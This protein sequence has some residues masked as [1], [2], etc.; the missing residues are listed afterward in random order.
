MPTPTGLAGTSSQEQVSLVWSGAAGAAGYIVWRSLDGSSYTALGGLPTTSATSYAD[1]AVSSGT[2][3]SY[4]VQSY[5]AGSSNNRSATT[6]AAQVL[7]PPAPPAVLLEAAAAAQVSLSWNSSTGAKSYDLLRGTTQ[8]GPYAPVASVTDLAFTDQSVS[9]S[10]TCFYVVRA[11]GFNGGSSPDSPEA[12]ANTAL[13]S[14]TGTRLATFGLDSGEVTQPPGLVSSN[15]VA[16]MIPQADG[17]YALLNAIISPDGNFTIEGVRQGPWLLNFNRGASNVFIPTSARTIDLGFDQLGRP[18]TVIAALDPTWLSLKNLGDLAPWGALDLF[19]FFSSNTATVLF[20]L[21]PPPPDLGAVSVPAAYADFWLNALIDGSRGDVFSIIQLNTLTSSNGVM[22]T[23]AQR[24]LSLA[25]GSLTLV[26][27]LE[28]DLTNLALGPV[29]QQSMSLSLKRTQFKAHLAEVNP[30]AVLVNE[31]VDIFPSPTPK[32]QTGALS[33]ALKYTSPDQSVGDVDLGTVSYGNPFSGQTLFGSFSLSAQARYS[34]PGS[35]GTRTQNADFTQ[36]DVL[37]TLQSGNFLAAAASCLVPKVTP[38]LN[39]TIQGLSATQ[40]LFGVGL[41]PT[42]A[43][44]APA[45]GAPT[46]Y[47]V[48]LSK[49]TKASGNFISQREVA[50]LWTTART[51]TVPPGLLTAGSYYPASVV[52]VVEPNRSFAAPFRTLPAFATAAA[53]TNRFQP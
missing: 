39:V 22:Y 7:T 27:G 24:A 18:D 51:L 42:F 9:P 17:S 23:S 16:A 29:P 52:S 33:D 11:T 50:V 25:A 36:Q 14:V 30:S 2:Q 46:Y 28:T 38:P 45:I 15:G 10:T 32:G 21:T 6:G 47:K 41:T 34:I 35:T 43:W 49:L 5:A 12:R 48:Q 44:S 20:G 8:G 1:S 31:F 53:L 13:S 26:D 3:Y 37:G 40:D 4:K 19:E